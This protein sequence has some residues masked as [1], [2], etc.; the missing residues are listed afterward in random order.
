MTH[1]SNETLVALVD[2]ELSGIEQ[3]HM[4]R[5]VDDCASCTAALAELAE[6]RSLFER[7]LDRLDAGEPA[8][9]SA[10]Q[11][12]VDAIRARNENRTLMPRSW[13]AVDVPAPVPSRPQ[14][15]AW[16][17]AAG[18]ILL[19][20]VAAAAI[21]TPALIRRVS[22]DDAPA[23]D[24]PPV[25]VQPESGGAVA[26]APVDG[27]VDV[28]LSNV[29]NGTRVEIAFHARTDVSVDVSGAP[30]FV[31][32][33]GHIGVDLRGER[34]ILRVSLP[35]DLRSG[36]IL[37]EGQPAAVIEQGRIMNLRT[38]LGVVIDSVGAGR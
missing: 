34:T 2:G 32:R 36:R 25:P 27:S 23:A 8:Q 7:L 12:M 16:R 22:T 18:L 13:A 30:G 14:P 31:A 3:Q 37:V 20:G 5:H 35:G 15:T 29:A 10:G 1:P 6:S 26:V 19:S 33:D 21:V 9:W 17:W 11:D 4:S 28:A 38:D 24:A